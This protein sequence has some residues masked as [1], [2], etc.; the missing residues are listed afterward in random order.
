MQ[1][2]SDSDYFANYTKYKINQI[3]NTQKDNSYI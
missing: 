1:Y 2:V 3:K